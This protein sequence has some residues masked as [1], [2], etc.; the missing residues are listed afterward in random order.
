M[1]FRR[2]ARPTPCGYGRKQYFVVSGV[3]VFGVA[4][5]IR[6]VMER[7]VRRFGPVRTNVADALHQRLAERESANPGATLRALWSPSVIHRYPSDLCLRE[8]FATLQQPVGEITPV[9]RWPQER[10]AHL[11]RNQER[12]RREI[13]KDEQN[14]TE[15][16]KLIN[17]ILR[18][19]SHGTAKRAHDHG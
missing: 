16:R 15:C 9:E 2:Y 1:S 4:E 13:E 12:A 10:A 11:K 3:G 6:L 5:V 17:L 18:S 19:Y 14:L 7:Y 8:R